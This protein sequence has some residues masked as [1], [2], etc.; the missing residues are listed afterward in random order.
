MATIGGLWPVVGVVGDGL[1]TMKA[2]VN[3]NTQQ[4]QQQQLARPRRDQGPTPYAYSYIVLHSLNPEDKLWTG[5][6]STPRTPIHE[7]GAGPAVKGV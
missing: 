7:A 5:G 4:Q 6:G 2:S 1:L 3:L